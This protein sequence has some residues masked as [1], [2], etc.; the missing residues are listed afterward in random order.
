MPK[1]IMLAGVPAADGIDEM[2]LTV[3]DFLPAFVQVIGNAGGV[4]SDSSPLRT[5]HSVP[6]SPDPIWRSI[7]VNEPTLHTG[8]SQQDWLRPPAAVNFKSADEAEIS[9]LT[10]TDSSV[11]EPPSEQ[12]TQYLERSYALHEEVLSSQ[13]AP[14]ADT[15]ILK[16]HYKHLVKAVETP[17]GKISNAASELTPATAVAPTPALPSVLL[18]L[19]LPN[20]TDLAN[21]PSSA[22]LASLDPLSVTVDVVI[23]II[24]ISAPR[25]VTIRRTGRQTELVEIL[26]GDETKRGFGI[27]FWI[28]PPPRPAR[29]GARDNMPPGPDL[30]ECALALRRGDV[31]C[32]KNLAL[33]R[34]RDV[35]QGQSLGRRGRIAS[36]TRVI[37][38][39]D[40]L[41]LP[42]KMSVHSQQAQVL[43]KLER[44]RSWTRSF[45]PLAGR[46]DQKRKAEHLQDANLPKDDTPLHG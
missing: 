30:R 13:I 21:I 38:I 17:A 26:A 46:S 6:S 42:S 36:A 2:S 4:A 33:S 32:V 39:D 20:L 25:T 35:V 24:S 18:T 45:V 34:F 10:A 8:W 44:V 12:L 11:G 29:S 7:P 22:T 41:R 19:S 27:T 31:V 23:G 14:A 3:N 1:I 28:P 37:K 9:F 15:P 43:D 16:K 40:G 5:I